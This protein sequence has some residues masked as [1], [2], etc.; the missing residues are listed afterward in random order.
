[1]L[2]PKLIKAMYSPPKLYQQPYERSLSSNDVA[3]AMF[4]SKSYWTA[5]KVQEEFNCTTQQ[6]SGF[7]YTIEKSPNFT[8]KIRNNT[9]PKKVKVIAHDDSIVSNSRASA[10]SIDLAN[11]IKASGEF[12]SSADVAKNYPEA[13]G[14]VTK[15]KRLA[16]V[17]SVLISSLINGASF[18]VVVQ[19]DP[20]RVKVI[21]VLGK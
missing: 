4:K 14:L 11:K 13:Q 5:K 9:P 2:T 20:R 12:W 6:A 10:I 15:D 18:E 21:K 17:C 19:K 8:V 7:L 3:I 1:M 16:L